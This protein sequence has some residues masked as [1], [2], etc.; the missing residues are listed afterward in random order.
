MR[1]PRLSSAVGAGFLVWGLAVGLL[2]LHDN[3][4]LTELASGRLMLSHGV[5]HTDP[6]S[7][8]AHGQPWVLESW[9]ASLLYAEVERIGSGHALQLL[10][11]V[12]TVALAALVWRLTRPAGA[13][14][15]RIVTAAAALVVGTGYWTP[16]PLLIAL[17]ALA[18]LVLMVEDDRIPPWAAIPLMWI[19]ANVHGSWPV[20]LVYVTVRIVGR[21]ADGRPLK[22][23]AQIA[24]G[25]IAGTALAAVNPFGL[26]LLSYPLV[27]ATHHQ[28]FAHIVEWESPNFADPVNAV[29]LASAALVLVLF[30]RRR[31]PL[32]DA[33]VVAVALVAACVASRNVPVASLVMVPVLAR[34]VHGLGTVEGARASPAA[35]GAVCALTVIAVV[36]V[37]TAL[38]RPAFV[39]TA[40]PQRA[41]T[42]MQAHGLAPGRVA[43][44]DFV[45]NYLEYRF[46]ARASAFVDDRVDMYPATVEG[47]Y[48]VLAGGAPGWQRVLDRYRIDTVLW[49]SNQPLAT[50]VETD[51]AWRVVYHDPHWLVASRVGASV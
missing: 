37:G 24:G 26:R 51:P 48:G 25:V 10:H 30:A 8:T 1:A 45:G 46:G 21:A 2:R 3:S 22:R 32:D 6:Y 47:A 15:G 39:F 44:Q 13:L 14:V 28:A 16:R 27:V 11:A 40:Y 43:T 36:L 9:L 18:V 23:L 12:L 7:F 29:F 38:R 33:L 20:A 49:A 41:V 17:V 50:L 34:S 42:W 5:P 31:A 4:F 35:L 19:W